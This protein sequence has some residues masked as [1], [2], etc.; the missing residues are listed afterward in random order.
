M[1]AGPVRRDASGH[2]AHR[3]DDSRADTALRVRHQAPGEHFHGPRHLLRRNVSG[4][5]AERLGDLPLMYS[6]GST[7][8][9]SRSTPAIRAACSAGTCPATTASAAE[10]S[11]QT[12]LLGST[13]RCSRSTS[14]TRAARAAE[15]RVQPTPQGPDG[16][17]TD[18]LVWLYYPLAPAASG[19]SLRPA[20][21]ECVR[22]LAQRL[23][24]VPA[25]QLS[26]SASS[27]SKEHLHDPGGLLRKN[28]S[29][30]R[31][32]A[33]LSYARIDSSRTVT[34][35]SRSTLYDPAARSKTLCVRRPAIA[36]HQRTH[37]SVSTSS[38]FTS[39]P[40]NPGSLLPGHLSGHVEQRAGE[41]SADKGV[42]FR[43]KVR[44]KPVHG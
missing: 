39:T 26:G 13:V 23:G 9:R 38:R 17:V 34:N 35:T 37:L 4:D 11:P 32:N 8:K 19:R 25:N 22:D 33:W 12:N 5:R 24:D 30:I 3:P 20:P 1:R 14:A 2:V 21:D 18:R 44:D 31:R 15:E 41:P 42:R 36:M 27:R 29:A 16:P 7:L 28:V 10:I 6:L 40:C 43:F